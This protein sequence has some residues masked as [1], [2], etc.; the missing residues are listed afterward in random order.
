MFVG[1]KMIVSEFYK[2]PIALSLG[3][4]ASVLAGSIVASRIWPKPEE[5]HAPRREDPDAEEAA[6]EEK[7]GS[8]H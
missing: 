7:I 8:G 2:I 3:I 6:A 5:A 4:V 1:V